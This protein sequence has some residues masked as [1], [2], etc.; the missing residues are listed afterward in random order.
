MARCCVEACCQY[1]FALVLTIY[2]Y[3]FCLPCCQLS[4]NV[5]MLTINVSPSAAL[6]L[7][8]YFMSTKC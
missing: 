1:G 7:H 8:L 6:S 5:V 4:Q 3:P 2:L